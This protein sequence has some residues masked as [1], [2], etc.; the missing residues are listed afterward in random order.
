MHLACVLD[1]GNGRVVVYTNG[2]TARVYQGVVPSLLGVG[3]GSAFL[4]R[5]LAGDSPPLHAVV[6]DFRI[7]GGRLTDADVQANGRAGAG[8]GGAGGQAGCRGAGRRPA[9]ALAELRAWTISWRAAT[10]LGRGGPLGARVPYA[11]VL[12][13]DV[14][15]M[16]LP[17]P[18]QPQFY[19]L[20]R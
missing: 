9:P 8:R 19:R 1:P 16:T 3:S 20:R 5:S 2:Q 7:Y 15:E 4:G 11:P 14:W 10:S 6:R 12:R 18:V 17:R 13:D